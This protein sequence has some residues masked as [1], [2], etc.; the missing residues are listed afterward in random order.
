[1]L[2]HADRDDLVERLGAREFAVILEADFD[3]VGEPVLDDAAARPLVLLRAQRDADAVDAVA[4]GGEAQQPAPAAAD[5][6]QPLFRPELQ[7]AADVIEL[8]L[9]RRVDIFPAALEIAAGIDHAA[10]EPERIEF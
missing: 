1:M 4:L 2:V 9:L 7:L 3:A 8:L 5:I 6:E 10:I